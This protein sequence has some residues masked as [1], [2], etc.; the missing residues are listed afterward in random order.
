[1]ADRGKDRFFFRFCGLVVRLVGFKVH[2][3]RYRGLFVEAFINRLVL[4]PVMRLLSLVRG[5]KGVVYPRRA[6]D[7]NGEVIGSGKAMAIICRL[8]RAAIRCFLAGRIVDRRDGLFTV[9]RPRDFYVRFSACCF[10]V[11][12][13]GGLRGLVRTRAHDLTRANVASFG[14]SLFRFPCLSAVVEP[15]T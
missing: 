3:G 10:L 1:M 5:F 9:R 12:I 11:A 14:H 6:R 15:R 2:F 13:D 7:F 4:V 8:R